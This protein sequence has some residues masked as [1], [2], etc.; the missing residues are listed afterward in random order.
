MRQNQITIFEYIVFSKNADFNGINNFL[1]RH[2]FQT[3]DNRQMA[4]NDINQIVRENNGNPAV[5]K[6]LAL[7]HPDRELFET[8]TIPAQPAGMNMGMA[9]DAPMPK[10]MYATDGD[11][12][13]VKSFFKSHSTLLIISATIVTVA[14]IIKNNK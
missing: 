3:T 1:Q 11:E 5:L 2:K 4:L 10:A 14:L 12:N 13:K 6:E 9:M 8:E 7:I